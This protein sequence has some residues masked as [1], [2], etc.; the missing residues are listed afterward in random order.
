MQENRVNRSKQ[1]TS[2]CQQCSLWS[3]A[4]ARLKR[5]ETGYWLGVVTQLDAD[6]FTL[7]E[8]RPECRLKRLG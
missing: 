6:F 1:Q 4:D 3:D 7:P 8:V 2:S 5:Q